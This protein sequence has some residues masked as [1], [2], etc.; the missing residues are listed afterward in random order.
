MEDKSY[1]DKMKSIASELSQPTDPRL[2]KQR[3]QGSG[4]NKVV[5]DYVTGPVV[6]DRLNKAFNYLWDLQIM[7]SFIQESI[8]KPEKKWNKEA[9]RMEAT[10]NMEH[11]NPVAH[12]HIRL[13]G[14]FP[15]KDGGYI[16]ITKDGFGC[17][18]IIGG[19][20]EQEN[21]FKGACTDALKK[22]AQNFGIALDLARSEAQQEYFEEQ[23]GIDNNPWTEEEIAKHQKEISYINS[24]IEA[25]GWSVEDIDPYVQQFSEGTYNSYAE[26]TPEIYTDFYNWF[27][28]VVNSASDQNDKEEE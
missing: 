5:L 13:T 7:N 19:Q 9:N 23:Q 2:I 10:G 8:D 6:I 27:N 14:Y 28:Q 18:S 24:I 15:N 26:L 4:R 1:T 11:Q 16:P 3:E 21:I 17:Q 20:S 22:A 25:S 12:V